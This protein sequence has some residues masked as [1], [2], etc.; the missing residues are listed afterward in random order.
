MKV[1][2]LKPPSLGYINVTL[3]KEQADVI[4]KELNQ[5]GFKDFKYDFHVSL[6]YDKDAPK[7]E[8]DDSKINPNEVFLA[9]V[10]DISLLGN[11]NREN[12]SGWA[13]VIELTSKDLIKEHNRLKEVG[14]KHSFDD[15]IPHMS[16]Y[17]TPTD[18]EIKTLAEYVNRIKGRELIFSNQTI[19]H[20]K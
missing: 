7:E 6:M 12:S 19:K 15:F 1:L 13:L 4:L 3:I 5:L 11:P 17:Y 14:Y 20:V 8:L 9:V 10:S 16:L 18:E 2:P